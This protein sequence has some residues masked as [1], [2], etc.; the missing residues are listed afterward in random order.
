MKRS[1]VLHGA[2]LLGAAAAAGCSSGESTSAELGPSTFNIEITAVNGVSCPQSSSGELCGQGEPPPPCP[3]SPLSAAVGLGPNLWDFTIQA[4]SPTCEPVTDFNGFVRLSVQPGAVDSI[5][6][7][8]ASGRNVLLSGGKVSGTVMVE[9]VYG[10]VRLWAEDLGYSPAPIGKIPE[11]SNGI[12]DNHNG[13][14]DW[15]ADPGCYAAD[16]DTEDG[17]SYTGGASPPVNYDLPLISD[18][19]GAPVGAATPYHNDGVNVKTASPEKL[20]VTRV[21][22]DGFF[23][24]DVNATQMAQGNNSVFAYYFSTPP[25]MR[26]CDVLTQFSGTANDFYGFTEVNFPSW[27]LDPYVKGQGTNPTC[28]VP[29]PVLLGPCATASMCPVSVTSSYVPGMLSIQQYE[30]SLV[31]VEGFTVAANFGPELA[32][33]N[34]FH[35]NQSNCDFNGDGAIEFTDPQE[36]SCADECALDPSCTEWTSFTSRNEYKISNNGAMILVDTSTVAGFDPTANRGQPI[37]AITGTLTKFSGGTLN[38]TI[39]ARCPDD[40]VCDAPGCVTSIV[41]AQSACVNLRTV[42]DNDEG[43]D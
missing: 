15:P 29:E 13:L 10:P 11:C 41:P 23:V 34:S 12:D 30:S 27:E 20:V 37:T 7:P 6:A 31:R 25:G 5:D 40:L 32:V 24:T 36:A 22:S 35:A 33:N 14:I 1:L 4:V 39:E 18:V 2:V 26:T 38:W 9:A 28:L 21:A 8:G 43:S 17:G 3:E 16:D 19:R 42:F